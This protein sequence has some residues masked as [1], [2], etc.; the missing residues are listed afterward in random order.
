M[1][2][3]LLL[4]W[5]ILSLWVRPRWALSLFQ[6]GVFALGI[7]WAA[8]MAVRPFSIRLPLP[9]WCVAAAVGW[10]ALQLAAG[11][12]AY[13]FV[14]ENELLEWL[15]ALV[16]LTVSANLFQ[17]GRLRGAFLRAALWFGFAVS[18]LSVLQ[19]FT[20][21]G[22]VFW[23][24][25]TP[26][27]DRV[28]GPF[29]YHNNY[30]AFIELLL[31]LAVWLALREGGRAWPYALMAAAMYATVIASTSRAGSAL[32]TAEVLAILTLARARRVL[33]GRRFWTTAAGLVACAVLFV[34]VVGWEALWR[35]FQ[36]ADPYVHRRDMLQSALAMWHERPWTGFGLGTFQTVYPA[37]AFFDIGL[38]VN[39]A[40]NDWAEWLAEGGTPFFVLMASLALWSLEPAVRS[41]WGLGV[42]SVFLHGLVDYPMQRLGLAAW[43]FVFVGALAGWREEV[44]REGL[45]EPLSL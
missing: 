31:P 35:R 33:S 16:L 1:A 28:M 36:Q 25:A 18:V 43:I 2:L 29:V 24:F 32:A 19:W 26:Y 45:R 37:Y 14:T 17:D 3:G 23:I 5:C 42:I 40:H 7:V 9:V 27:R 12:T 10:I 15:A 11:W 30:A 38:V 34:A 44:R 39:H 20:S 6:A 41:I 13:R 22:K 21:P 4:A 8:R